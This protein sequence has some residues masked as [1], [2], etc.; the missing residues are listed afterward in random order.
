MKT[1][2]V[3][4]FSGADLPATVVKAVTRSVYVHAAIVLSSRQSET[5][6]C[7][8]I[9]AESH[10]DCSLPSLGTGH[11]IIGVQH[12]WLDRRLEKSQ[13]PVW[14]VPLKSPLASDQRQRMQVWLKEIEAK[15]IP[16]DFGQVA[17]SAIDIG[18]ELGLENTP[19]VSALFCSEL[20]THALQLAGVVNLHINPAEQ[21]PADIIQFDCFLPPILIK[22]HSV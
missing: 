4:M 14:W 11:R 5:P 16:Y 22:S 1:G 8:V 20:V 10:V 18:D 7:S 12:Q 6:D 17:G 13:G 9:I 21:V 19:N 2:D 15:Q 3:V